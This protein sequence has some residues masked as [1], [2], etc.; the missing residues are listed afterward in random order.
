MDYLRLVPVSDLRFSQGTCDLWFRGNHACFFVLVNQL[1]NGSTSLGDLQ[2]TC[3]EYAGRMF[4]LE[5]RRLIA[6]KIYCSICQLADAAIIC[7]V[8]HPPFNHWERAK[9]QQTE[10][11][12]I[13]VRVDKIGDENV[14]LEF[15]ALQRFYWEDWYQSNNWHEY[16]P[17]HIYGAC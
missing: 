4:T 7:N 2:L 14:Y 8:R 10:G 9:M 1:M 3:Y 6:L 5:H 13:Y 12:S 17:R 11:A 15:N 16:R